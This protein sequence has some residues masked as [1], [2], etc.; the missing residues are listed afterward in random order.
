GCH[1]RIAT[2]RTLLRGVNH[3]YRFSNGRIKQA[4]RNAPNMPQHQAC[5]DAVEEGVVFGGYFVSFHFFFAQHAMSKVPNVTDGGLKLRHIKKV[6]LLSRNL[7]TVN[8]AFKSV[9]SSKKL[10]KESSHFFLILDLMTVGKAIK[11]V[12]V[13]VENRT[14]FAVNRTFFPYGQGAHVDRLVREFGIPIGP[15]HTQFKSILQD[16]TGYRIGIAADKVLASA[17][18][19][20]KL[21]GKGYCTYEKGSRPKPD[22]TVLPI[23]EKSRK[24]ANIMPDGQPVSLSDQ[25]IVEMIMFPVVNEACRVMEEGIVLRASD[26]DVASILGMSFPSYRLKKLSEAYGNFFRPSKFLEERARKG[27]PLSV[28]VS[29]SQTGPKSRL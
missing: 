22:P 9:I 19:D 5:I 21:N 7:A 27:I 8:M 29:T 17:F 28:P 10:S 1:A 20:R 11:K 25:E 14:S 4:T 15:F 23:I 2:P 13:I 24:L 26:L 6:D 3:G 12:P 18:G 16:V